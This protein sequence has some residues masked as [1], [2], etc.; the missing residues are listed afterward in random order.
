M[1]AAERRGRAL[2]RT[3]S[4]AFEAYDLDGPVQPE[5]ALL[6]LS[7]RRATGTG[8]YLMRMAPGAV[9]IA[10][11][12]AGLE[13]FMVLEGR[14][15]DDDGAVFEAGDYVIYQPGTRHNSH[16]DEG[17]LLLVFEWRGAEAERS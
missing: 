8:S 5:M 3:G 11:E 16:T 12:H 13:E 9:T 10:H 15:V 2:V 17:C 14:L 7:Y 1:S 6:P 4:A